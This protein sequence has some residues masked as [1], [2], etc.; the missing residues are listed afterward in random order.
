L[1]SSL[2]LATAT[3]AGVHLLKRATRAYRLSPYAAAIK[4]RQATLALA[5]IFQ[6]CVSLRGVVKFY[7]RSAATA[8]ARVNQ[9]I[10]INHSPPRG[11]QS[12][13]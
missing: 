8:A 12:L 3:V 4:F 9:S 11:N 10:N 7:D 6:I 5:E 2:A 1:S 13:V